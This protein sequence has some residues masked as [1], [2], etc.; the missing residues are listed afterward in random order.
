M[1]LRGVSALARLQMLWLI[2]LVVGLGILLGL[3]LTTNSVEQSELIVSLIIVLAM[4]SLSLYKPLVAIM[5]WIFF[6]PFIE[7]YI[8]IPLGAGIPDLSFGRFTIVFLAI[9]MLAQ[10]AIGKLRIKKIGTVEI[11]IVVATLG[12]ALAAPA[13]VPDP[14]AV[15]QQAISWYLT[16][17]VV[18]IFAKNFVKSRTDYRAIFWTIAL[19]GTFVALYAAYEY[20][21][22]NVLFLPRGKTAESLRL[23]R[24]N[25]GI[26]L[27]VGIW[28]SAAPLGRVLAMCIPV[29]VYLFLENKAHGMRRLLLLGM[30]AIQSYS[31]VICMCRAPWYS[32]LIAL[33]VLQIFD[34]RFRKLFIAIAVV[35]V[36]LVGLTWNLVTESKVAARLND[37]VSTYEGRQ[38]R[39]VTAW[40]MALV[41]PIRGWGFGR[42]ERESWRF[43]PKVTTQARMYA[44]ENDYLVVLLGSGLVGLLP[45]LGVLLLPL[46]QGLRLIL[47][48]R[49]LERRGL[50]WPGFVNVEALAVVCAV[51]ICFLVFSFSAANVI[52]STKL[53]LLSLTGAV[54]GSHDHLL[55]SSNDRIQ[56]QATDT[57]PELATQRVTLGEQPS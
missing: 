24:K 30:L 31:I 10:A 32:C 14:T 4:L 47:A 34:K 27:I 53:I 52:A 40:R 42:F 8:K 55:R 49:S 22:G 11:L 44:P 3:G 28:G 19:L 56:L 2:L 48:A 13:S 39:W 50:P 57:K 6:E 1:T 36:I 45:Y 23:V 20:T 43:R 46:W 5:V 38:E 16:P 12:I 18:Y 35:A 41:R 21:T 7:S 37:D 15:L 26:R 54:I 17:F 29:S 33:F 25:L 51:S 9:S